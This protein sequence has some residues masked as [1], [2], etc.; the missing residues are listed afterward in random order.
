MKDNYSATPH[1]GL[2]THPA[3][4]ATH[5]KRRRPDFHREAPNFTPGI[6]F[7]QLTQNFRGKFSTRQCIVC[8][9]A[10]GF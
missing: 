3:S 10:A 6:T 4:R 8:K 7:S 5:W 2:A 9:L 1:L